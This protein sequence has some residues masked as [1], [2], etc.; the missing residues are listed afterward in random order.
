MQSFVVSTKS[1]ILKIPSEQCSSIRYGTNSALTYF[2]QNV[3]HNFC[4][5]KTFSQYEEKLSVKDIIYDNKGINEVP[6]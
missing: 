4:I 1:Q 5:S 6:E 2:I 3:E